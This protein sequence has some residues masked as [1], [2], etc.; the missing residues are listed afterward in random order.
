MWQ[1]IPAYLSDAIESIQRKALRIVFPN[2]TYQN[3]IGSK[4]SHHFSNQSEVKSKPIVSRACTFSR[5]LFRLRIIT[6]SFDWF[7]GFSPSFLIGQSNNFGFG[8]TTLD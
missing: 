8:F 2:S 6:S 7:T 4:F 5:A 3:L 1:G